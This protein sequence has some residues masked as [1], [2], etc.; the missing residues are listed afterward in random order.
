MRTMEVHP[1]DHAWPLVYREESERLC[2][3]LGEEIVRIHHIGSTSVPELAAKPVIDICLEVQSVERLDLL[4]EDMRS[5]GYDPRGENGIPGRRFYAK[6]G[7]ERTHHVHAFDA[8][9]PLV[10]DHL[11]FRDYLRA[12]PAEREAYGRLKTRVSETHRTDPEGYVAAKA[13]FVQALLDRARDWSERFDS[14]A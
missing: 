13:E 11:V 9:N 10:R 7:D 12:S 5:L 6:G 1:Y 8:G 4:D 2:A 14:R 3:V